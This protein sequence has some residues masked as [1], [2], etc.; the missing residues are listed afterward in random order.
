MYPDI[1]SQRSWS[2]FSEVALARTRL[3]F[4]ELSVEGSFDGDLGFESFSLQRTVGSA[5]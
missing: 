3:E 2:A 5:P 1:G 4:R